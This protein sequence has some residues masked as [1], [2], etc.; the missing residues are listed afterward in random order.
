MEQLS[1]AFLAV[2]LRTLKI[3]HLHTVESM[4]SPVLEDETYCEGLRALDLGDVQEGGFGEEGP[5]QRYHGPDS[6]LPRIPRSSEGDSL[7]ILP[8]LILSEGP[9]CV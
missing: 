4:W 6:H 8:G 2:F 5:K 3:A 7:V 1:S 9:D